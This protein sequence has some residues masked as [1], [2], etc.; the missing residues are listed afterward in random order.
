MNPKIRGK[1]RQA[2]IAAARARGHLEEDQA[3][4]V[5][6]AEYEGPRP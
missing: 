3:R 1:A 4:Y 2:L 5:R 6:V